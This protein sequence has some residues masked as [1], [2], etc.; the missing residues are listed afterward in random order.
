MTDANTPTRA[1]RPGL[2]PR[3]WALLPALLMLLWAGTGCKDDDK[4]PP[5]PAHKVTVVSPGTDAQTKAQTALIDLGAGDTLRFTA[6]TFNFTRSL[7]LDSKAGVVIIGAGIDQTYLDFSGQIDGAEGIKITNSANVLIANLT[8]RETRGDGVKVT[9]TDGLTMLNVG[10]EWAADGDST[11]G[12]YG[13]YPVKCKNVLMD[14]CVA[15]GASDAGIY[16]GQSNTVIVR[17]CLA[18]RNVAGIEIENTSN[19]DVYLNT[20][21]NNTGGILIFDLPG[22]LIKAGGNCRVFNNTI[23]DNNHANFAPKGNI[24]AEVPVGTGILVL[25]ARNIRIYSNQLTNNNVMGIGTVSYTTLTLLNSGF[26]YNDPQ[27]NP[28]ISQ[29]YI[30]D[31]VVVSQN[32]RPN[33]D[34]ALGFFLNAQFGDTPPDFLY[35]GTKDP[36]LGQDPSAMLCIRNNGSAD[37]VNLNVSAGFTVS[38]DLAPHD[39]QHAELSPISVNSPKLP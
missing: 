30:H 37:F 11:N 15:R 17:N 14:G 8:V 1:A 16:V 12:S 6:G 36:A 39:C 23:E 38:R 5:A 25:A 18:E 2:L 28:Y 19:A 34:Q 35:D 24:V 29:I 32:Q 9:D 26:S 4:T 10:A 20:S 31:N 27:F 22:L 13:L 21:R 7:T 33:T 3:R